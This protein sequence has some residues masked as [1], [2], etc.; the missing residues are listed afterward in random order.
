MYDI[1]LPIRRRSRV[2]FRKLVYRSLLQ[3]VL[4]IFVQDADGRLV[5]GIDAPFLLRLSDDLLVEAISLK[6]SSDKCN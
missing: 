2:D 5:G 6:Q 3:A 4:E 1:N